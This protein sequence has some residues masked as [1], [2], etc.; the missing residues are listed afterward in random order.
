MGVKVLNPGLS[1]TIQDLGRPGYFHLGIPI[2]G[3]M[4]QKAMRVANLLVGNPESA[5]GLEIVF[6]GPSLCFD[7][8]CLIAVTGAEMP[9]KLDGVSQSPWQSI[10]VEKGQ[11]LEFDYLR[12]G[13]RCY[14]SVSGGIDV[15]LILGSR[16]T[17]LVG[18]FGGMLGRPI[19]AGD[20]LPLGDYDYLSS[21]VGKNLPTEMLPNISVREIRVLPGLYSH[22]LTEGSISRF[23]SEKWVV[24]SEADRMGYRFKGG[25]ALEFVERKA[26]FGAGS[27]PSNIVDS[28]YAYGSIQVPSGT[29]PIILHR[30][31]V[32]AGGYFTLGAVISADMDLIAQLQ[33]NTS[34]QFVSIDMAEALAARAE[35]VAAMEQIRAHILTD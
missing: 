9:F 12:A 23:F 27:D 16:S 4:D 20:I 17:Y 35:R 3:A 26:P 6:T 21:Q 28:S 1:T 11:T 25:Q 5:A 10:Q 33:P 7:E 19:A 22:R 30:D 13:A 31:A 14:L 18:S 15:P 34:V 8:A 32:S 29:E 24:A 2:S